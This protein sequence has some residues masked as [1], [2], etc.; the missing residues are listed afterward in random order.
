LRFKKKVSLK[1]LVEQPYLIILDFLPESKKEC[2]EYGKT[3]KPLSKAKAGGGV[4]RIFMGGAIEQR[5]V[6]E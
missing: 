1:G 6:L 4:Q 5:L 3:L 2:K